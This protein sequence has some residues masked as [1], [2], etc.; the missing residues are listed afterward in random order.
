MKK[1]LFLLCTCFFAYISIAMAQVSKVTGVVISEEDNLPIVGASVLIKG[2]N[3]GTVTDI[4]G[5][6]T[7]GNIPANAKKVIISFIGMQSRE[8]DIKP[9]LNVILK[10]DTEVLD[11]VVVTGYGVTKKSTFTG[12]AN[13][14]GSTTLESRTDANFMKALEGSMPGVQMNNST[15]MPG[16]Q[17]NVYIRGESSVNSG[18]Q[19]LYIID[20]MPMNSDTDA[21]TASYNRAFNPLA[22]INTADIE[23]VTVLK[24]AN[25]TAIY[26]SRAANGVIVITTKKGQE[27]AMHIDL[28]IKQGFTN[29]APNN[30]S[31]CNAQQ[32]ADLFARG[33]VNSDPE[34]YTYESAMAKIKSDYNWD[35]TQ[36][37][38]WLDAI[39]RTGYYQDYNISF[40]GGNGKTRY[41]ASLGYLNQE[42]VAINSDMKRYSARLNLETSYKWFNFG[43]N[44]SFALADMD[45][46]SQ[47]TG[48]SYSNPF[49]SATLKAT[50]LDPFYNEDGSY[51]TSISYNPLAVYDKEA[52][53]IYNTKT[54]TINLNPYFAINF[55]KGFILKTSLGINSYGTRQYDFWSWYNNQGASD[56]GRG[57]Q[58]NS[59]TTTITW[60]NTL[61]WLYTFNEKHNVSVM[62]GQEAQWKNYWNEEYAGINFPLMGYRE[63]NMA[64]SSYGIPSYKT[65]KARLASFFLNTSYDYQGKYY[66]QVSYRRDG[67]SV[68]GS[69]N[70]WGN[71]WSV[72]GKWRI[73]EEE[74]LKDNDVF[75]NLAIRAS[76]GTVGNQDIDWYASRGFYKAG[77][78]Y[79]NE[80]GIAPESL[81]LPDLGWET[82]KKLNIGLDI[83]LIRKWNLTVDFY[84]EATSD[85]LFE[86]PISKVTG[87]DKVYQN[88]GSMRNRGVEIGLNGTILQTK[89]WTWTAYANVTFNQNRVT[90]LSDGKPVE[91]TYTIIQEGY[92]LRQFYMVEY[93]GVD[94]GNPLWYKNATGDETTTNWNECAKRYLGSADPKAYGGFGTRLQWKNFDFS[95]DFNYRLG[96]KVYA[97]SN[98]FYLSAGSQG[99]ITPATYLYENAWT[100]ENRYTDVPKYVYGNTSGENNHSSRFLYSGN[101]L[102]VKNLQLGYTLP[103]HLL[104]KILIDNMRIYISAD[105]IYTFKAKDFVGYDPETYTNGL[106]AFQYPSTRTFLAGITLGF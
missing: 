103:K 95:A 35:G 23:S 26:G 49:V 100:E 55:G 2:T 53:D 79:N 85:M 81:N 28:D 5:K 7:L 101:F 97:S 21:E 67:S 92:P 44:T 20:G 14:A 61:N 93:A 29:I 12:A 30:F 65:R 84:N 10:S 37:Y 57:T 51:N 94:T 106:I 74:F 15:S 41:Y 46:F 82:S 86:L 25:A 13:V 75:T 96:G 63:L 71:F 105:N 54:T 47:S 56:N 45:A 3:T 52:G 19:P 104:K 64:G 72:G 98:R 90:E 22:N 60:T 91:D 102:R 32:T 78:N 4:D 43:F 80:P 33:L 69:N 18:T 89:G 50:P 77:Y 99:N 6:F 58:Y 70:R 31:F 1:K 24:D 83:T 88:I 27:G 66:G 48:G 59:N 38:D 34:K 11:E 76:Y 42:G 40:S 8:L 17:A 62:L 36:N 39:T 73:S 16:A 68:F 87:L 9:E